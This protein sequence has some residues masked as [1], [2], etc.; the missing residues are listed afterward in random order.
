M[1]ILPGGFCFTGRGG[2]EAVKQMRRESLGSRCSRKEKSGLSI[3]CSSWGSVTIFFSSDWSAFL[4]PEEHTS[5]RHR[6]ASTQIYF[7][8][9]RSW[10]QGMLQAKLKPSSPR[11]F[12]CHYTTAP[13]WLY[14]KIYIYIYHGGLKGTV[15]SLI[16]GVCV[17][18]WVTLICLRRVCSVI[19]CRVMMGECHAMSPCCT[20][21]KRPDLSGKT[22]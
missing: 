21:V 5:P 16:Q 20:C 17:C 11:L 19:S 12:T 9:Y 3:K 22:D 13:K 2:S 7:I 14:L 1:I 8:P 18:T 6:L 15:N 10:D 4:T